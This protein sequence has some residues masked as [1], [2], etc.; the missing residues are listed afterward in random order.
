[1]EHLSIP[2]RAGRI[3]HLILG[4]IAFAALVIKHYTDTASI[5]DYII[6]SILPIGFFYAF[7][8]NNIDL[9]IDENYLIYQW[10]SLK[11]QKI[12]LNQIREVDFK[13]YI[14]VIRTEERD[15]K[16]DIFNVGTKNKKSIEEFLKTNLKIICRNQYSTRWLKV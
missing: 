15:F 14:I 9:W 10:L 4:S 16:L 12:L 2:N 3:V 11:K 13:K 1:M 5:F 7:R 8:A 6:Y